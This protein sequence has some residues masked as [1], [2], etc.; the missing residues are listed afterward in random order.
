MFASLD[1]G[2]KWTCFN[3]LYCFLS[4]LECVLFVSGMRF[5]ELFVL[6]AKPDWCVT[7]LNVM[8][9]RQPLHLS[10]RRSCQSGW[11]IF[12][13][14]N[15]CLIPFRSQHLDKRQG[16]SQQESG[17]CLKVYSSVNDTIPKRQRCGM[18]IFLYTNVIYC[19]CIRFVKMHI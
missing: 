10:R 8:W 3:N 1:S 15:I 16:W 14:I 11:I 18:R 17:N 12:L 6:K 2:R 13:G 7:L 5:R 19:K 9:A 4:V